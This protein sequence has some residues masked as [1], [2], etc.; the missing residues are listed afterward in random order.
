MNEPGFSWRFLAVDSTKRNRTD[1][2]RRPHGTVVGL[3]DH[4]AS[5]AGFAQLGCQ[6]AA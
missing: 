6:S 1:S 4:E 2:P 3:E 5:E